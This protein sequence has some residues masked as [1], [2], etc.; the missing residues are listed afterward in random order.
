MA[1]APRQRKWMRAREECSRHR[2]S[3]LRAGTGSR[4]LH[5]RSTRPSQRSAEAVP[6][7]PARELLR[8]PRRQCMLFVKGVLC[9]YRSSRTG[10][11]KLRTLRAAVFVA[12][13]WSRCLG[14]L[15]CPSARRRA[16][17]LPS[18]RTQPALQRQN[19]ADSTFIPLRGTSALPGGGTR[20]SATSMRDTQSPRVPPASFD[21]LD[22]TD[23][24][25]A[26]YYFPPRPS[27]VVAAELASRGLDKRV[28]PPPYHGSVR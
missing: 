7:P 19:H 18:M 14:S 5:V 22:A 8:S 15:E 27:S 20:S 2:S 6:H 4:A 11:V 24:Q 1:R 17:V 12:A 23:A 13:L 3:R 25:L 28:A 9:H 10:R 21:P 26:Y 16:A